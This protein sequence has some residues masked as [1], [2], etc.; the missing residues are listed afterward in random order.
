MWLAY[1]NGRAVQG[2]CLRPL[3]CWDCG[4]E[5]RCGHA[6]LSAVCC[7]VEVSAT[8]WSLVQSSLAKCIVFECDREASVMRRPWPTGA[9]GGG[10]LHH[11]MEGNTCGTALKQSYTFFCL[12]RDALQFLHTFLLPSFR[13][14]YSILKSVFSL[15]GWNNSEWHTLWS[16]TF[17]HSSVASDLR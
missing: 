17:S 11:A 1:P 7:Q 15:D 14:C 13:R 10:R 8:G 9:G 2:V 16:I 12:A 6:C 5:S 3:A 4:F